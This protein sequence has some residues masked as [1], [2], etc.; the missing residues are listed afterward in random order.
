MARHGAGGSVDGNLCPPPY[1]VVGDV[2]FG[3]AGDLDDVAAGA[4]GQGERDREWAGGHGFVFVFAGIGA[5]E[6][7][8]LHPVVEHSDRPV[9]GLIPA[10]S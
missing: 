3:G 9:G 7:K 4:V 6:I 5:G 2:V 8:H 1:V 10:T